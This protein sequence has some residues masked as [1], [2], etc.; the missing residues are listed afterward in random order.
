MQQQFDFMTW[1]TFKV[2][3]LLGSAMK[4]RFFHAEAFS[5]AARSMKMVI[6][7]RIIINRGVS[8]LKYE[9]TLSRKTRHTVGLY[10]VACFPRAVTVEAI[11]TSKGTQQQNSAL[12]V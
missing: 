4:S 7:G 9:V 11:E 10:I 2:C 5:S 6:D 12:E 8:V 1:V 3:C